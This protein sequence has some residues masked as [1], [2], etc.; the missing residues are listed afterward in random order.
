MIL[1][2]VRE[3]LYVYHILA[4]VIWSWSIYV[5][6]IL[7]VSSSARNGRF[8]FYYCRTTVG[9]HSLITNS[10]LLCIDRCVT[11]VGTEIADPSITT[12]LILYQ[13][14]N[15]DQFF[16]STVKSI[17]CQW[18]FYSNLGMISAVYNPKFYFVKSCCLT[19]SGFPE[20]LIS[21]SFGYYPGTLVLYIHSFGHDIKA[22]S[23]GFSSQTV[24]PSKW[25]SAIQGRCSM[26]M[27]AGVSTIKSNDRGYYEVV[28]ST[29]IEM[30]V[31]TVTGKD[32]DLSIN[33]LWLFY[34]RIKY[35]TYQ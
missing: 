29:L 24:F 25:S 34:T 17:F 20:S 32:I 5:L 8:I 18:R 9:L 12:S 31:E 35:T 2:K 1:R 27:E 33:P 26:T 28:V 13:N 7:P 21:K 22:M 14:L 30:W 19:F 23:I 4:I 6:G 3:I 15:S 10:A 16:F 11:L